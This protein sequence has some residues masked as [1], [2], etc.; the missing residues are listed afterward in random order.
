M[1]LGAE[2]TGVSETYILV[3]VGVGMG[4]GGTKLTRYL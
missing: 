2:A 3:V 4:G 1:A